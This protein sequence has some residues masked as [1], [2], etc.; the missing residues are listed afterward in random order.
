MDSVKD[1]E[2]TAN[3]TNNNALNDAVVVPADKPPEDFLIQDPKLALPLYYSKNNIYRITLLKI[4]EKARQ[5]F[6]KQIKPKSLELIYLP[7]MDE[8]CKKNFEMYTLFKQTNLLE[9]ATGHHAQL[10]ELENGRHAMC[11]NTTSNS[12]TRQYELLTRR[13]KNGDIVVVGKRPVLRD[14]V[15]YLSTTLKKEFTGEDV[16]DSKGKV[17]TMQLGT[18]TVFVLDTPARAVLTQSSDKNKAFSSTHPAKVEQF[19]NSIKG[20]RAA[21]VFGKIFESQSRSSSTTAAQVKKISNHNVGETKNQA[22]EEP[23]NTVV[24]FETREPSLLNKHK[25][26]IEAAPENF[27]KLEKGQGNSNITEN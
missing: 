1:T 12:P 26:E 9:Y 20:R 4:Q 25:K 10:Y 17:K 11:I 24:V 27:T 6:V 5:N 8:L 13:D 14:P 21:E 16:I 15:P 7:T 23:S 3:D 2:A 18:S 22:T 19:K